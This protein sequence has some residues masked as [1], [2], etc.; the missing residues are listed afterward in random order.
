[1]RWLTFGVLSWLP[2]T[3]LVGGEVLAQASNLSQPQ[4]PSDVALRACLQMRPTG[5]VI[6]DCAIAEARRQGLSEDRIA[7]AW[8]QPIS[9]DFT[10]IQSALATCNANQRPPLIPDWRE[11]QVFYL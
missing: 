6:C 11:G 2:L 10:V 1:M 8:A 3:V 5:Q 7:E 9:Q 4:R